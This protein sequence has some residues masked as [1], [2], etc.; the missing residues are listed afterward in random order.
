MI[1]NES[2]HKAEYVANRNRRS[3][4]QERKFTKWF[5]YETRFGESIGNR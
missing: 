3:T 2:N 4:D 1:Q 5:Y